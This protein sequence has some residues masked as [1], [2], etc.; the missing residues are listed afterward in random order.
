MALHS[1]EYIINAIRAWPI[2]SSCPSFVF[3]LVPFSPFSSRFC[4]TPSSLGKLGNFILFC[5][6]AEAARSRIFVF[7]LLPQS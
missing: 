2:L 1:C 7:Y 5:E 6:E 3:I 4:A